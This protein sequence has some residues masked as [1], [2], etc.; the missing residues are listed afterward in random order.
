[1]CLGVE[2]WGL[3]VGLVCCLE[4][5]ADLGWGLQLRRGIGD[6]V[7]MWGVIWSWEVG[8]GVCLGIERLGLKV[9]VVLS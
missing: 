2:R 7:W 9:G 6:V 8:L 5:K 4:S 3:N 1:M